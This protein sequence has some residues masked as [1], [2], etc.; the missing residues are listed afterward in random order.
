MDPVPLLA[1]LALC[2]AAG[3]DPAFLAAVFHESV[4]RATAELATRIAERDKIDVVALGGGVF[5]NARLVTSV[6]TRLVA[7]GLQV[8]TARQLGPN[9]GAVSY[10]QAAVAAARLAHEASSTKPI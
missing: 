7:L 9:D 2:A 1:E 8:L 5:Q 4:A 3:D 6:Q 10:G